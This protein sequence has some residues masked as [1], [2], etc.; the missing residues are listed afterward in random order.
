MT[1]IVAALDNLPPIT[2][3]KPTVLIASTVKGKGV[4]F[5][6]HDLGWHAGALSKADMDRAMADI[7]AGYARIGGVK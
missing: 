6:E 1:Q 4:K 3:Q 2:S 7:E 5:M